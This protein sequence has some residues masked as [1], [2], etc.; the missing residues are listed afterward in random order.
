MTADADCVAVM[1][2]DCVVVID[3]A[4]V[5]VMDADCVVVMDAAEVGDVVFD[6]VAA[7]P[8]VEADADVSRHFQDVHHYDGCL[9]NGVRCQNCDRLPIFADVGIELGSQC[10][11]HLLASLADS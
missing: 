2:A 8:G 1:D 11:C 4:R 5:V 7:A 6:A 9:E 10:Q 3:A